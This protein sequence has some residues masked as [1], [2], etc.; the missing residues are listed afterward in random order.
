M[1]NVLTSQVNSNVPLCGSV[2]DCFEPVI[3]VD[4]NGVKNVVF[5]KVDEVERVKQNGSFLDWKLENLVAAGVDPVFLF[6]LLLLLVL[7]EQKRLML[8]QRLSLKLLMMILQIMKMQNL[9]LFLLWMDLIYF[10]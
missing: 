9:K 7:M 4:E 5:K 6:T 2:Q 3:K 8:L 1:K 10:V